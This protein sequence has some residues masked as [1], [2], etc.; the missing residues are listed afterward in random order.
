[1]A[2][3]SRRTR[4][5]GTCALMKFLDETADA[6]RFFSRLPIPGGVLDADQSFRG[7][8]RRAPYAGA[9]LGFGFGLMLLAA[10][11]AG[12]TPQVAAWLVVGLAAFVTG[13]MHED[14]LADV[15][16]GFGGGYTRDRRLEIMR[17]SRI[18]AFGA[19]ALI[20]TFGVRVAALTA[21]AAAPERALAVMVAAGAV[22]RAACLAPLAF[23]PPA[24]TDGLGRGAILSPAQ[25][26]ESGMAALAF[27]FAPLLAGFS[28]IACLASLVLAAFVVRALCA[29]S[30]RMIGGQTGDVAG[31]AQQLAEIVVLVVFSGALA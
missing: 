18:G 3:L 23:L 7:A 22:S 19:S 27:A 5:P 2:R 1:M 13:A 28:L 25:A 15:A 11:N 16:D 20:L 21:L 24:R 10:T 14:G 8:M 26:R 29:W 12:A 4:G 9:L 6:L 17:D 30:H 31:A